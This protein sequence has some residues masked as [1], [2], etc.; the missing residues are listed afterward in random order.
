M[1]AAL[2]PLF[3]A[4]LDAPEDDQPRLALAA[5]LS[6]LGDARG[7]HIRLACPLAQL[8]LD[9]AG[10]LPGPGPART[11]PVTVREEAR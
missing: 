3:D 6:A 4:I 11:P 5:R 9:D 2:R 1:D 7:E 8:A 10:P